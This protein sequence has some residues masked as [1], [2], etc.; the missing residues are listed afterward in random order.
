MTPLLTKTES[1]MDKKKSFILYL[2]QQDIFNKLPDE[3][4]G[5]LIKHIFSYVNLEKPTTDDLL[6]EVAFASIK[7]SL[8]RDLVKWETQRKQRSEAGKRSA[9]KRAN[10][11]QRKATTVESRSTK[12]TVSVSD[13]VSVSVNK[14]TKAK[15]FTPPTEAEVI[16]YCQERN[17]DVDV[18]K[19]VSYYESNGW[20]VG[21]NKMKDWKACVRSW[22]RSSYQ[23]QAQGNQSGLSLL[24][25]MA[26]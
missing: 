12:S 13:S 3:V 20:M 11:K 4:A 10:E 18:Y 17:N 6:L 24:K 1:Y 14:K 2:D 7:Q 5:K 23:K 16:A 8:K 15:K 19:F 25:D 22:E 9:E 26:R 21:K